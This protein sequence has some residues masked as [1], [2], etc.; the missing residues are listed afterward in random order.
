LIPPTHAVN[1][2]GLLLRRQILTLAPVGEVPQQ[3]DFDDYRDVG[4]TKF[5]FFVRVSLMDPW[6]SATRRYTDVQLGP[7]VDDKVFSPLP[8]TPPTEK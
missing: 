3:T 8:V 6:N 5:P 4:R 2:S 7:T 1:A